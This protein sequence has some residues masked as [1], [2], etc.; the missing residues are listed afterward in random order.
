MSRPP[1]RATARRW[2]PAWLRPRLHQF[3]RPRDPL[4]RPLPYPFLGAVAL[5][6]D[7]EFTSLEWF[8]AVMA[9]MN[10]RGTTPLG[11]GLGLEV[12]SSMFFYSA[13]PYTLSYF[14]GAAA[15]A[16][17]APHAARLDEY[18]RAGWIDTN[19]AYG[20][21]DFTGGCTRAHAAR[22][23]DALARRGVA[24]AVFTNHGTEHNAQNI[25]ADAAYHR[26]D[27]PGDPAWH[28]DLLREAGCRFVW[29]DSLKV[30]RTPPRGLENRLRTLAGDALGL[31]DPARRTPREVLRPLVLQDGGPMTG[32]IRVAG[33]GENAP[34]L[35]NMGR[36]FARVGLGRLYSGWGVAVLYQHLG[37]ALRR[38]GRCHGAGVAA[39]VR[40]PRPLEPLRELAREADAGRL[41]V[42]GTARLLHYLDMIARVAVRRA[43][44][45]VLEVDFSSD[46]VFGTNPGAAPGRDDP[47]DALQGLTVFVADMTTA[48]RFRGRDLPVTRNGP[49]AQGRRSVSVPLRKLEDIW[50]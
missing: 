11:P 6:N 21:F 5:S 16:P 13:H 44:P 37:V 1:A 47:A 35:G 27:V 7:I 9:F 39:L 43:E 4:V 20:D 48:L 25:G 42:A 24:L 19:H 38:A 30:D 14:Q 46:P 18:L 33:T 12:A 36:Q 49:D 45:G 22:A 50:T 8:E 26:G 40:D 31:V 29:T 32:F 15:D 23:L 3:A 2:P 17:P 28:A 34:N 10:S 41:W